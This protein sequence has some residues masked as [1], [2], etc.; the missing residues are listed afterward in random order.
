[1]YMYGLIG[2][3]LDID[4]LEVVKEIEKKRK[5]GISDFVFYVNSDGGEVAQGS[6]IF[7]YLD[8]T[9]VNVTWVVDGIAASMMAVLI[10]N[11]KHTVKAARHAKFMYHRVSGYV[12][13]N[14]E[15]VRSGADMIDSFESTLVEMMSQR[16]NMSVEET[17]SKYFD[18]TDHWLSAEQA[19]NAGLCDEIINDGK[20]MK[21]LKHIT[22]ARD[23][24]NF[25]NNQIINLKQKD[26]KMENAK[27]FAS[28]L[29]IAETDDEQTVLNSVKNVVDERQGLRAQLEAEK[30]KNATLAE[31]MKQYEKG[32]VK[33]LVDSAIAAK[34]IGED[35]RE[36]YTKLA[37]K[38]YETTE[39]VLNRMKPVERIVNSIGNPAIPDTEKD[40]DFDK[41]H[42]SGRLENLKTNNPERYAELY[43]AKFGCDPKN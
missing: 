11:P 42:K 22:N 31:K 5:D 28:A 32:K 41:Y 9:D 12:Y 16:L 15:E 43:K 2:S 35:D 13:G 18:G 29:G 25:Y 30:A 33:S 6:A 21:E 26:K 38:D 27:A 40:W 36:N 23:A 4:A 17:R 3:G 19:V 7:N 14:S 37:E 1:M 10:T 8:R 39:Q 24:F 34:K 20:P